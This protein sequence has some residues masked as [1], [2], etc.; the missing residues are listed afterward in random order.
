MIKTTNDI[1]STHQIK[2]MFQNILKRELSD[3]DYKFIMRRLMIT[4]VSNKTIQDK[5]RMNHQ[6]HKRVSIDDYLTCNCEN[7]NRF[8]KNIPF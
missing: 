8:N 5:I 2:H 7:D 4:K 6:I 1:K 3:N